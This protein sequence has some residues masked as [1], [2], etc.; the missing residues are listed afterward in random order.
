MALQRIN[1]TRAAT[2]LHIVS[3][4]PNLRGESLSR[5]AGPA[6]EAAPSPTMGQRTPDVLVAVFVV[7][8]DGKFLVGTTREAPGM[9]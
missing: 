9:S 7:R 6:T 3:S 4:R 5:P 8:P 1:S 2:P